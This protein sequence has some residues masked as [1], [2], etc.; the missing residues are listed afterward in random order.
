VLTGELATTAGNLRPS[1]SPDGEEIIFHCDYAGTGVCNIYKANIDGTGLS[2]I[3]KSGINE[4]Y[5]CYFG[6]PR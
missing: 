5:P 3:T 2:N 4:V 1:V 6:K